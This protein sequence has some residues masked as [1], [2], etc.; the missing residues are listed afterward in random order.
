MTYMRNPRLLL[1]LPFLVAPFAIPAFLHAQSFTPVSAFPLSNLEPV[2]SRPVQPVQ[3]FTVAG[4][5][6][7]IVGTQDGSFESWILPVKLLSHLT[8]EANLEGYP[9]PILVNPQSAHIEVRPDRTTITYSHTGFTLR[10]IMFS[11]DQSG[12]CEAFPTGR[13]GQPAHGLGK[14]GRGFSP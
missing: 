10:Q 6:G 11:P 12:S 5:R 1:L 13:A 9:V 2:I 3:P 14:I 4:E 7:V 8:I